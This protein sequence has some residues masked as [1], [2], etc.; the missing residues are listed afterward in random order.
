MGNKILAKTLDQQ[1]KDRSTAYFVN[2]TTRQPSKLQLY[3][4][5]NTSDKPF[6]PMSGLPSGLLSIPSLSQSNLSDIRTGAS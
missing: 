2:L 3:H 6:F 1:F 5:R 4:L